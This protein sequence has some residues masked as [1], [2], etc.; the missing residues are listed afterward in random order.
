MCNGPTIHVTK[1]H[2]ISNIFHKRLRAGRS[3][4]FMSCAY[5]TI[6]KNLSLRQI[7][8]NMFTT[9]CRTYEFLLHHPIFFVSL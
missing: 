2:L 3:P 8:H 7:V 5:C 4:F 9:C 1:F 6:V